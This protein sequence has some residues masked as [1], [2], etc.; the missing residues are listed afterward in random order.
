MNIELIDL[1]EL[2]DIATSQDNGGFHYEFTLVTVDGRE[3]E[4]S[5]LDPWYGIISV[6]FL[7][8]GFTT[9]KDLQAVGCKAK[10]KV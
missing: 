8:L 7:G 1:N 2:I 5:T 6:P 3:F 9:V 4:A 10:L